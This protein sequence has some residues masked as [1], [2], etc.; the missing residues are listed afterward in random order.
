[1]NSFKFAKEFVNM[2]KGFGPN[3]IQN[4]L[5]TK[6]RILDKEIINHMIYLNKF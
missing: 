6:E 1:L 2:P 3:K 4:T 5:R